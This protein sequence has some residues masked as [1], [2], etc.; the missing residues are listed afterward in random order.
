[1]KSS[2]FEQIVFIWLQD[3]ASKVGK[4][5]AKSRFALNWSRKFIIV[6]TL[7]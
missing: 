6:P 1:M 4:N 3:E 7:F 2:K 5:S